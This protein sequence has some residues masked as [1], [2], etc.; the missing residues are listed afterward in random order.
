MNIDVLLVSPKTFGNVGFIAR[1]MK[2]FEMGKLFILNPRYLDE[3]GDVFGC[4]MHGRD[5]IEDAVVLDGVDPVKEIQRLGREKSV[6]I[7]TTARAASWKKPHRIPVDVEKGSLLLAEG[8]GEHGGLIVLGRE[9]TGLTDAELKACDVTATIDASEGY[10]TL[11][12]SHAAAILLHA[13]WKRFMM[14]G[15]LESSKQVPETLSLDPAPRDAKISF[16]ETLEGVLSMSNET[17]EDSRR[18][19]NFTSAMKNLLERSRVSSR[20]LAI[21]RGFLLRALG[22]VIT[23]GE[24]LR[25]QD[26][27]AVEK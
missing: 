15:G 11:N 13:T 9:D 14:A 17:E 5:I 25:G 24:D 21:I 4:A 7:G 18:A 12:L 20:E 10:P 16:Y 2:N 23:S 19:R 26:R 3:K 22:N 1:L 8:S 27:Q 6:V